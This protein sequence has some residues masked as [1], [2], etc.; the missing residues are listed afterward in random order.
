MQAAPR[1]PRDAAPEVSAP[2]RPG[3]FGA[4]A[5]SPQQRRAP[6]GYP[7]PQSPPGGY[8]APTAR[9]TRDAM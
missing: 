7:R 3:R 6:H 5:V 9:A 4:T 1:A 2:P 8:D